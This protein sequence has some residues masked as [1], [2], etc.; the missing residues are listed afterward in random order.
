MF[1][2]SSLFDFVFRFLTKQILLFLMHLWFLFDI[3]FYR[4]NNSVTW[5][6]FW[7]T[8]KIFVAPE[9]L[10]Y[11]FLFYLKSF[12]VE[13]D[14]HKLNILYYIFFLIII[15]SMMLTIFMVGHSSS[16]IIKEKNFSFFWIYNYHLLMWWWSLLAKN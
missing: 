1:H 7:D 4:E 13:N 11:V 5:F 3:L 15:I 8:F 10:E 14:E 12:D 2:I 9:I 6:S 16:L